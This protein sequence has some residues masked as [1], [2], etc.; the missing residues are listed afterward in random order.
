MRKIFQLL[1]IGLL[2]FGLGCWSHA[3]YNATNSTSSTANNRDSTKVESVDSFEIK[4]PSLL[5]YGMHQPEDAERCIVDAWYGFR[6]KVMGG[7]TTPMADGTAEH[8]QRTDSILTSR[9]GKDWREK[10]NKSVDSLY[11]ID[12]TAISIAKADNYVLNFD[13]IT[14]KHNLKYDFYPNLRYDCFPTSNDHIKVITVQGYGVVRNKVGT[15]N[16]LTITVDLKMKK[17]IDIYKT[18][19]AW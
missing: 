3:I 12:T 2:S 18:A 7:C 9:I 6:F 16:Y 4:Y 8:N 5:V 1:L 11:A 15:V 14:E 13:T 10:F 17:V 19:F